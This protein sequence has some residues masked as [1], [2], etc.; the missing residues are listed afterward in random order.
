M[1]DQKREIL[2]H[3]RILHYLWKREW[4]WPVGLLRS[5]GLIRVVTRKRENL[6]ATAPNWLGPPRYRGFAITLRHTTVGRTSLD[7]WSAR[8]RD[9]E[10][11]THN[12]HPCPGRTRTR[13]PSK[14]AA[15]DPRLDRAAIAI[16]SQK[17]LHIIM[18]YQW[19]DV[20]VINTHAQMVLSGVWFVR[21]TEFRMLCPR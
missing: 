2:N 14:R 16:G 18:W 19:C 1:S 20:T 3:Q 21:T 4:E 6:L 11:T 13:H 12:K 10:L 7:E 8:R 17:M 5:L 15:T 9:L